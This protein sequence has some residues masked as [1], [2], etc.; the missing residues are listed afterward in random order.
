M[1]MGSIGCV[2]DGGSQVV[3]MD[4]ELFAGFGSGVAEL[5]VAVLVMVVLPLTRTVT[6]IC[7]ASS[8]ADC[9]VAIAQVTV[10]VCPTGGFINVP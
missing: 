9:I 8:S 4:A 2:T 3:V 6:L 1:D 5:T 7:A 10:P